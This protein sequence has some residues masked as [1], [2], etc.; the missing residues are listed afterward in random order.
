M[1]S[2][3][4]LLLLLSILIQSF[5]LFNHLKVVLSVF[6]IQFYVLDEGHRAA[7]CLLHLGKSLGEL[8]LLQQLADV[9]LEDVLTHQEKKVDEIVKVKQVAVLVDPRLY[10]FVSDEDS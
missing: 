8:K 2:Q 3:P 6:L 1:S 9:D 10:W 5:L 4:S 7:F